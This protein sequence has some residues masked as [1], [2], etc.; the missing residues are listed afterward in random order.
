MDT[1]Q[2]KNVIVLSLDF[3]VCGLETD[4]QYNSSAYYENWLSPI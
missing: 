3:H 2:I 1:G 4:M